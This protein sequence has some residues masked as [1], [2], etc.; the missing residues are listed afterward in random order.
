MTYHSLMRLSFTERLVQANRLHDQGFRSWSFLPGMLYAATTTWW[1]AGEVRPRPHEGLDLLTFINDDGALG[2]LEPGTMIPVLR[3][4]EVVAIFADFLGQ[5]VLVGHDRRQGGAR[6]FSIYGHTMVEP[7][8]GVGQR[9]REGEVIGRIATS[10]KAHIP[11]HLHLSTLWLSGPIGGEV[12]WPM[13]SGSASI[14][15][16]DPLEFIDAPDLG[17]Q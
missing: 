8:L 17:D 3:E 1:V 12:S 6:F 13:I 5:S 15:Q 4:G 14:R 9:C 11:A 7:G 10:P 2:A 16:C